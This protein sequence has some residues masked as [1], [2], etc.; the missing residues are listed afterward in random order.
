[1]QI[2]KKKVHLRYTA[3]LRFLLNKSLSY[4]RSSTSLLCCEIGLPINLTI[5]SVFLIQIV[6]YLLAWLT[7]YNTNQ[8]ALL[9]CL[10]S[11]IDF[12]FPSR[13]NVYCCL[14]FA[15]FFF[16]FNLFLLIFLASSGAMCRIV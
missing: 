16:F 9:T 14:F 3:V 7:F 13:Y 5:Y 6:L 8:I 2:L 4:F 10:K 11:F 15:W 1:M 12:P